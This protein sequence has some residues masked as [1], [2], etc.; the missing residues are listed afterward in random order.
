[1]ICL[2]VTYVIRAGAEAQATELFR[3]LA[4]ATRQEPGNV[5]YVVHRSTTDARR[6]FLYEQYQDQA[7]LDAH[8]RSPHF[9]TYATNGLF[10]FSESRVAELYAPV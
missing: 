8:R 10:H 9:E 3:T 1:M 5:M 7:A 4:E 6:F 2:T